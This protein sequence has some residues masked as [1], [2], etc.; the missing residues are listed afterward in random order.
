MQPLNKFDPL[1]KFLFD[2]TK[3]AF[4]RPLQRR[5]S[6]VTSL[7]RLHTQPV[8]TLI[9]ALPPSSRTATHDSGATWVATPSSYDSFI[10]NT[11]TIIVPQRVKG[12][13]ALPAWS[14]SPH[15]SPVKG[16]EAVKFA[17]GEKCTHPFLRSNA[18]LD[19]N[20][21]LKAQLTGRCRLELFP[22][23]SGTPAYFFFQFPCSS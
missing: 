23:K 1:N 17:V 13:G 21:G 8:R 4:R 19:H 18:L 3:F 2:T 16:E 6:E 10:Y 9:N 5:R 15:F 22:G 11:L 7:S 14:P 20:T 12:E